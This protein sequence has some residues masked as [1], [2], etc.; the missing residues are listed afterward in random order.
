MIC[1][2]KDLHNNITKKYNFI[3]KRIFR[4]LYVVSLVHFCIFASSLITNQT[5][6]L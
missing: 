3:Q 1:K 4:T 6:Q 5:Y 2:D